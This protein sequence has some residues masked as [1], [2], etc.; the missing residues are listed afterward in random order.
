MLEREGERYAPALVLLCFVMNDLT[1]NRSLVTTGMPKPRY[2]RDERGE[3]VI[4]G[5][6]VEKLARESSARP[7]QS[8]FERLHERSG[9]LQLLYPL[10]AERF[11][12]EPGEELSEPEREFRRSLFD[13]HQQRNEGMCDELAD[14]DSV[15]V[16]LLRRLKAAC[17]RIGAPLAVMPV[18]HHHDE[19]LLDP[20][21]PLP[22]ELEAPGAGG[23]SAFR[24]R[25]TR[26]LTRLGEEIGF[27][28]I[29]VDEALLEAARRRE[30]LVVP[31]GH[32]NERGSALVAAVAA[33]ALRPMLES[34]RR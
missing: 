19:Y 23:E 11:S 20:T 29:S 3:W 22:R 9:L 28:V 31:D 24:T 18:P 34:S 4:E 32:L 14:R 30:L 27:P 7:A 25:L 10:R 33:R 17:D 1:G 21:V 2:A 13:K 6:P 16:M 26:E 12:D 15:H 8:L 5:R